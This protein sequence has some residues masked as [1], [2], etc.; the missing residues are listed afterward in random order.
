MN[1]QPNDKRSGTQFGHSVAIDDDTGTAV[2]G[3]VLQ[4]IDVFEG[5]HITAL[6]APSQPPTPCLCTSP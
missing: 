3:S 5:R 1:V 4:V 6:P 2:V